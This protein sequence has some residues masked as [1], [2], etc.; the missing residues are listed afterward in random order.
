MTELLRPATQPAPA[1]SRPAAAFRLPAPAL[2]HL[3]ITPD[4]RHGVTLYAQRL[5]DALTS[6][7][8]A[9]HSAGPRRI[10]LHFTD[11]LW[12]SDPESAA[13]AIEEIARRGPVTVTLHDLPQ[14]SDGMRGLARRARC[15]RRVVAA[16]S[17]V[18]CNSRH[19]SD[20]LARYTDPSI[21]PAVIPLPV[22]SEPLPATTPSPTLAPTLA[23]ATTSTRT[24]PRP[25]AARSPRVSVLG[26]V[27]PGKGHDR[28]IRAVA[29][30]DRWPRVVVEAL[31]RASDG[32]ER[33][34]ESIRRIARHSAVALEV[35]GFLPDA[36][37]LARCRLADVPVIAHQHVSASGSLATWLG[38]GRR[39]L[40][41]RSP[42]MEEMAELH[43]GALTLVSARDLPAAIS[44]ALDDP[45]STWLEGRT[46]LGPTLAE[47]AA[48]YR[49]FWDA[50]PW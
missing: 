35:S 3:H 5:A 8:L 43:R 39:P 27:Y 38:A 41:L 50:V 45:G 23:P 36:E 34:L 22:D 11:R 17:G 6:A 12:G 20:L 46:T 21:V 14:P 26:Y 19:E 15:Y 9:E 28:T 42:Y 7:E 47:T 1:P 10:H 40:V 16:A 30:L 31:G 25:R 48:R 44:L 32:H 49:S 29:A 13:D 18:V 4:P 37:L 2:P 33:D 24:R